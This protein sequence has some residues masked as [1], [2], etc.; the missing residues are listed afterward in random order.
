MLFF[1]NHLE[2]S[3][4]QGDRITVL[5]YTAV[6]LTVTI[7]VPRLCNSFLSLYRFHG[8]RLRSFRPLRSHQAST[9]KTLLDTDIPESTQKEKKKKEKKRQE[10]LGA[11]TSH[12]NQLQA[13]QTLHSNHRH[14]QFPTPSNKH[15]LPPNPHPRPSIP[16]PAHPTHERLPR[17]NLDHLPLINLIK[18]ARTE[19]LPHLRG[20]IRKM[21]IRLQRER[22]PQRRDERRRRGVQLAE[23]HVCE[24]VVEGTVA[25]TTL[26]AH[27]F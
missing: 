4:R 19:H 9:F 17:H 2:R 7:P 1:L 18:H 21:P 12:Q 5:R 11:T 22:P 8:L 6:T 26:S 15:P 10:A 16:H 14:A 20:G 27:E 23:F 3:G 24:F 25:I 13:T